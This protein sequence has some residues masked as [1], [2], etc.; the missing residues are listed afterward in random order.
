MNISIRRKKPETNNSLIISFRFAILLAITGTALMTVLSQSLAAAP[1]VWDFESGT[2]S[3][4]TEM[5]T[6]EVSREKG[7]T[8]TAESNVCLRIFGSGK[9]SANYAAT[10]YHP[11]TTR[12]FFRLSAWVRIDRMGSNTS[13]PCLKCEFGTAAPGSY[14][15]QALI[16]SYDVKRKGTWQ[17]L[18]G[19]FRVPYGTERGR[20]VLG[21][22]SRLTNVT[23][24]SREVDVYLDDIILEQIEHLSIEGKYYLDPIPSSLEKV[25]G[26]HPRMYLTEERITELRKAIKTTHASLW[27][28]VRDQ[29]DRIVKSD[30]PE[31]MDEDGWSNIE[32]LYMRGVGNNMPLLAMAYVLTG[33]QK[34]FEGAK[35][36]ALAACGYPTWGLNE[37][38][39]VDLSTGH[40]LYGLGIVYDWLYNDLDEETRRIIRETLAEKSS[41]LFD[42]AA[43]GIIVKDSEAYKKHPWPEWDEAYLQNHLWIN[44]CG[45]A[46]AGLAIFDEVDDATRWMSLTLD[47]YRR[48]MD[49][50]GDDGASH[51]GPGDWSYG[52]EWMLKFMHLARELLDV[53]MYAHQWW[54]NTA[55]YRLYMSLPQNSWTYSNTTVDVGDSRRYDW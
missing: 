1:V 27:Q 55:M 51:E 36:W 14:L 48:T 33:E 34:Y 40:Q 7:S 26:V 5:K 35:K 39:N 15:G 20:I 52:V 19:E 54:R 44:S 18:T 29:A 16:D 3:W 9:G 43:K 53:D 47:K 8:P 31:Y 2:I 10:K 22:K 37:F 11:M 12:Q 49:V 25:R 13:L 23:G 17:R 21:N 50:L 32:Q 28:E 46:V 6:V 41:Y 4:K 24:I 45:L 42:V 38:A 30:P